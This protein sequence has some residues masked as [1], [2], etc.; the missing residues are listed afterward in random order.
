MVKAGQMWLDLLIVD[1]KIFARLWY[2]FLYKR[3]YR[4]FSRFEKVKGFLT[5]LLYRQ[6]GRFS[7]PFVHVSMGGLI[8]LG[9]TLAPVLATSFPGVAADPLNDVP[10]S[11]LVREVTDDGTATQISTKPRDKIEEYIVQPGDTVSAIASKYQIDADTI[12]WENNLSSVNDIKPGQTLRILPVSGVSHKVAR[13]ETIYSIAKKYSAD[14]QGI[15][16]FPFNTFSD[17]ETFA[18]AVGQ[19]LIV[20]DGKKPNQTPWSPTLATRL[21][22]DAGSVSAFGLFV[23]PNSGMIT[24]RYVWYHKGI[25]IANAGFPPILAADSGKVIVAGW[26]DNSGYGNRIII[27]HGNGYQTLYGHLS[28]INVTVGQTVNRGDIIGQ[29]G[30]TGRS[31]GPHLHFEIHKDGIAVNPL[32]YLK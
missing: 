8:A 24:Q 30:S 31:T 29:E 19:S 3:T 21:T 4:W 2:Q 25:D 12:R 18:L 1:L 22:P 26:P 28:K 10:P 17:N 32:N 5:R 20:P 9:V 15:V 14:A 16:D 11:S 7:R 23:W 27:D 13:G 6:R